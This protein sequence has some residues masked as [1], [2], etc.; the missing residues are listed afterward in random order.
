[1]DTC[2]LSSARAD[3]CCTPLSANCIEFQSHF[4][5][6]NPTYTASKIHKNVIN[7]LPT[8][9]QHIQ[10][11]AFTQYTGS[12]GRMMIQ[13]VNTTYEGAV[14]DN[15]SSVR[16]C[17][18]KSTQVYQVFN[19]SNFWN[20]LITGEV[21]IKMTTPYVEFHPDVHPVV[22]PS[23]SIQG[24]MAIVSILYELTYAEWDEFK[25]LL[26]EEKIRTPYAIQRTTTEE[27]K[28]IPRL[29]PYRKMYETLR[30]MTRMSGQGFR[31]VKTFGLSYKERSGKIWNVT[32]STDD[33]F[34]LEN[35]DDLRT[36][37][38][39]RLGNMFWILFDN[40]KVSK[41]NEVLGGSTTNDYD[42]MPLSNDDIFTKLT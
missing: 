1:M 35:K 33:E 22:S 16:F 21:W 5:H 13:F 12:N 27:I 26:H 6:K 34:T 40:S 9:N 42:T 30:E 4:L 23:S 15:G 17:T 36:A 28:K 31:S 38:G 2:H 25:T 19:V 7:Q 24:L 10:F 32:S 20:T 11:G 37:Q 14:F 3:F 29:Y 8:S 39:F 41:P 18:K